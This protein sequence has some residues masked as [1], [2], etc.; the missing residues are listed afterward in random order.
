MFMMHQFLALLTS[1][2]KGAMR[3]L[4]R[5]H[6]E[7]RVEIDNQAATLPF[8]RRRSGDLETLQKL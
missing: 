7:R 4:P 3:N 2:L 8:L 6:N 5:L 1:P